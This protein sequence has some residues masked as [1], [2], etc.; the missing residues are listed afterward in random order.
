MGEMTGIIIVD[1]PKEWT[2]HDVIA[3]LR[4]LLGT[5][6]IGHSGTLDPMA[7]G[8]LAVF[9][10]RATRVVEFAEADEKE[11]TAG[12]RLG[13]KTDTQD[14]WGT[15]T[16]RCGAQVT[17]S[18][19]LGALEHFRGDI[20]QIPPMYSAVK[21]EGKK[22][23][24]LARKGITVER[25]P[26]DIHIRSLELT[27]FA[28]NRGL[29]DVTGSKGT[30]IR[31]LCSDIG[32]FLKVGG[33]MDYLRRTRSGAF[34]LDDAVT[35]EQIEQ[36]ENRCGLLRPVDIMFTDY[37]ALKLSSELEHRHRNGQKIPT[38]VEAGKYRVY[39]EGEGTFLSLSR[40]EHRERGNYLE[41]IKSFYLV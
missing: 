30:Y 24:E 28:D 39:S 13:I 38:P 6:R 20:S 5:R 17:R 23:Y 29:F 40:V 27:D 12:L 3:K 18:E 10:G 15:V 4:G 31:T 14:I 41:I 32:D 7:T 37:P 22:L 11:Y 25:K 2:S 8:V 9:V 36:T 35:L 16:D 1:K 34:T 26:R 19:L 33:V 21:Q